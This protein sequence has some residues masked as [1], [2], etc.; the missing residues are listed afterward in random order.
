M[1]INT[2][3]LDLWIENNWNVL[4]TGRHGT[5]K[6]SIIIEAFNRHKLNWMYFSASTMDPWVDFIGVPKEINVNGDSYLGLVRP[7]RFQKDEVEA[8]F[9]DEYNRCLVGDTPIQLVN[10]YSVKIKDL[11][12]IDHF[13]VYSYDIKNKKIAIGKGHSAKRTGV[14]QK[15]LKI[16]LDNGMSVRCTPNHPFLLT[17]REYIEAKDLHIN[18]S[19]MASYKKYNCNGY[20]LVSSFKPTKWN[21]TY[22][23][24]DKYDEE[25]NL[26]SNTSKIM[27]HRVVSIEEDGFEDVYDI[28]VDNYH[29]FAIGQG[30]FVHNS[31]KKVRNSV[32][33]LIQFKSINGKKFN[34]LRIVWAAINPEEDEED[35]DSLKYDVEPLDPAQK[36]RFHIQIEIPYKCDRA[37]FASKYGDGWASAAIDWWEKLDKSQKDLVSPRRLDYALMVHQ[38]GGNL[39]HVLP[40]EANATMLATTLSMGDL[41]KF[42]SDLKNDKDKAEKWLNVR[43]NFDMAKKE[44]MKPENFSFFL[45]FFPKEEIANYLLDNSKT[46]NKFRAKFLNNNLLKENPSFREIISDVINANRK[47]STPFYRKIRETLEKF[48]EEPKIIPRECVSFGTFLKNVKD[49]MEK[50]INY[51]TSLSQSQS[52]LPSIQ[53]YNSNYK[54]TQYKK[55]FLELLVQSYTFKMAQQECSELLDILFSIL[56]SFQTSTIEKCE[57]FSVAFALTMKAIE[58]NNFGHSLEVLHT[59]MTNLNKSGKEKFKLLLSQQFKVSDFDLDRFI[60]AKSLTHCEKEKSA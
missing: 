48:R 18:D 41:S 53:Y 55:R 2:L 39:R 45:P 16:T 43:T 23:L 19:L 11:V 46:G 29:N 33:E 58:I 7:E 3:D 30:I 31:H 25:N 5:G 35:M 10:G 42:I 47:N 9:F 4:F 14:K 36:D 22:I 51:V 37:Y 26:C 27:N 32:M 24:S 17:T 44:I 13:Y 20:E 38:K 12:G 6:S 34:N 1:L 57:N 49:K 15:I 50:R 59:Y 40:K 52:V 54:L 56:E 8:I 21:Y 28:T 60:E